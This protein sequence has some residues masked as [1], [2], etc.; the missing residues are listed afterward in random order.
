MKINETLLT[1]CC[2]RTN[3]I[4]RN[5]ARNKLTEKKKIFP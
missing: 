5:N 1:D 3:T 4:M 2:I